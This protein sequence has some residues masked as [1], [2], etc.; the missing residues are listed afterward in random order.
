[1][2]N[3]VRVGL[4]TIIF[5]NHLILLHKRKGKH[6]PGYWCS[7][8]GHL[9]YGETWE[10]CALREI[11]E[12]CGPDLKIKDLRYWHT[13]DT[14]YPEENK[15]YV[16][17][18]FQAMYVSGQAQVMEPDKC[19]LWNWFSWWEQPQP[20]MLGNQKLFEAYRRGEFQ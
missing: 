11:A 20:L 5:S 8:G 9:E 6:K 3:N 2:S 18:F 16:T 1:M 7:P 4:G 12:E 17:I 14:F 19:E 13:V 15:H 10:Q